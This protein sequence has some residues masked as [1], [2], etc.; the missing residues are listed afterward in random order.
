LTHD[1]ASQWENVM[2]WLKGRVAFN[3]HAFSEFGALEF[4]LADI[5]MSVP[6]KIDMR[7]TDVLVDLMSC[8][9]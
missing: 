5:L 8:L 9:E 3:T 4:T 1:A 7:K 2:V 6:I